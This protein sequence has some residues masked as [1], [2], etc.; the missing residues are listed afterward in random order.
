MLVKNLANPPNPNNKGAFTV[1]YTITIEF[2]STESEKKQ[3]NLF[4]QMFYLLYRGIVTSF[5]CF[6]ESKFTKDWE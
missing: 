3:F 2:T 5:N 1:K 4:A 6:S